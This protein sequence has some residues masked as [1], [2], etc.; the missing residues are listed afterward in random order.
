MVVNIVATL[1]TRECQ[2]KGKESK[3]KQQQKTTLIKQD[4]QLVTNSAKVLIK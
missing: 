3:V 4:M 1:R 2:A